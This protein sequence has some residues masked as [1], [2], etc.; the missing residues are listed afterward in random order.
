MSENRER[1]I[2]AISAAAIML[3]GHE[4]AL[5][6]LARHDPEATADELLLRPL[7]ERALALS[8]SY[9][10]QLTIAAAFVEAH[11]GDRAAA[12]TQSGKA[13]PVPPPPIER[14]W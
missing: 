9:K 11:K 2:A 6:A 13:A 8:R 4:A 14:L 7:A 3:S 1:A 5:E 12:S 10:S